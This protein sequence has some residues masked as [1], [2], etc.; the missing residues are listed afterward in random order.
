M[1]ATTDLLQ[2]VTFSVAGD[3]FATDIFSVERVLRYQP[4]RPVP[5]TPEWLL[6]VI[7]YQSRVV[8]ILDIRARLELPPAE[9]TALT[10]IV[11]FDIEAQ[12]IGVLVDA[13]K[14]VMTLE[15]ALIEPPPAIFR[16]LTKEY[17]TGLLRRADGVVIVLDAAKLFT[18]HERVTFA[19]AASPTAGDA[20]V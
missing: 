4:A 1:A 5:N 9:A 10:R 11:V 16:G 19:Q 3:L 8:P 6:G 15:R 18:S 13:V 12:W 2:I 20:S 7:D 14:E 17:L